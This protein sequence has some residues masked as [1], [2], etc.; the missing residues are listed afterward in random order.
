MRT[1]VKENHKYLAY[2][3]LGPVPRAVPNISG[4]DN[5]SFG[6]MGR[7]LSMIY[8]P[9]KN[10]TYYWIFQ[11]ESDEH[12]YWE[13]YWCKWKD[14]GAWKTEQ[15][16][17]APEIRKTKKQF[18]RLHRECRDRSVQL[19]LP[20]CLEATAMVMLAFMQAL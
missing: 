11:Y 1:F 15:P 8:H 3:S 16:A 14:G 20:C 5:G 13:C 10:K 7:T 6:R 2:F 17:P 9:T 18:L 19:T 12:I 4:G